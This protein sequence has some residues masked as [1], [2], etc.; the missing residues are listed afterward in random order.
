MVAWGYGLLG[1]HGWSLTAGAWHGCPQLNFF[2]ETAVLM[3]LQYFNYNL[4]MGFKAVRGLW[5]KEAGCMLVW[6]C[7]A[8][9]WE[10][11][12]LL[13]LRHLMCAAAHAAKK[14]RRHL[15]P[16]LPKSELMLEN[17]SAAYN[18]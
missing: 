13:S 7:W 6:G 10:V 12:F 17:V 14:G 9:P 18:T 2:D 4:K 8:L 11:P 1:G 16:T 3:L 15:L 5:A